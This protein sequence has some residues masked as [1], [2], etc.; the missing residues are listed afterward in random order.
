MKPVEYHTVIFKK[1]G[2]KDYY[3]GYWNGKKWA[4]IDSFVEY[5]DEDVEGW[6]YCDKINFKLS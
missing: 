2:I 6:E 3:I 5:F 4:V 1:K